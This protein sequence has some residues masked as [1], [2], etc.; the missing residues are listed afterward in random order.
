VVRRVAAK[1]LEGDIMDIQK[2]ARRRLALIDQT[3]NL[4]LQLEVIVAAR[5]GEEMVELLPALI[6]GGYCRFESRNTPC[7]AFRV[8]GDDLCDNGE[9]SFIWLVVQF[10]VV[11]ESFDINFADLMIEFGD[12]G[13]ASRMV[14][15]I[16]KKKIGD[17]DIFEAP[18]TSADVY[19]LRVHYPVSAI[20]AFVEL[21]VF[22]LTLD[23]H[24]AHG[25]VIDMLPERPSMHRVPAEQQLIEMVRHLER[26]P[27][28]FT[29]E[30]RRREI[31][32]MLTTVLKN[33]KAL[34]SLSKV[35]AIA[36]A[37]YRLDS[38]EGLIADLLKKHV[39]LLLELHFSDRVL[40]PTANIRWL[41]EH[42]LLKHYGSSTTFK[43]DVDC[44]L[45]HQLSRGRV[46][47]VFHFCVNFLL[48][49]GDSSNRYSRVSDARFMIEQV[50][51]PRAFAEVM[52]GKRYGIAAAL[53]QYG[54]VPEDERRQA[55]DFASI[56]DQRMKLQCMYTDY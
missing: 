18:I 51:I 46:A 9:L 11:G 56:H 7:E 43:Q 16:I 29:L 32:N 49:P 13:I 26:V 42:G 12:A 54:S 47:A 53:A 55:E 19:A 25:A 52:H 21:S 5:L 37:I 2:V 48:T 31:K 23:R 41:V 38:R 36:A 8:A 30:E 10:D 40:V 22:Y 24:A 4:E 3:T 1:A 14:H 17:K 33:E 50:L 28:T 34:Y 44:A 15:E 20:R 6:E 35:V 27:G 39:C 45:V